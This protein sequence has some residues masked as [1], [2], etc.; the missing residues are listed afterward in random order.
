AWG[1][2]APLKIGGSMVAFG[3]AGNPKWPGAAASAPHE[4]P[5]EDSTQAVA[6]K[7]RTP[8]SRRPEVW[9]AAMGGLRLLI[10]GAAFGTALLAA[11]PPTETVVPPSLAVALRGSEFSTLQA[12]TRKDGKL[13]LHGRLDSEELRSRLDSWL[14]ERQLTP[15]IDVQVDETLVRNVT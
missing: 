10:C 3:R 6:R 13:E 2:H 4:T 1:M 5:A 15:A 8:L 14:A 11:P 12:A 9:L 7:P